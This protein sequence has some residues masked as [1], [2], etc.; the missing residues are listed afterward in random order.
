[1]LRSEARQLVPNMKGR[2]RFVPSPRRLLRK[3]VPSAQ[4]GLSH[5]RLPGTAVPG[6][7]LPLLRGWD[8]FWTAVVAD[9]SSFVTACWKMGFGA[10]PAI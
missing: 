8:Q 6:S 1:M 10:Q 3:L 7:L 2:R 4:M 5:F 9:A